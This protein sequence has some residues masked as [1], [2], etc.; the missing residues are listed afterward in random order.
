MRDTIYR[1]DAIDAV[2]CKT[3]F[4][5]EDAIMAV[6]TVIGEVMGN[7]AELPSAVMG[8]NENEQSD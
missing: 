8:E 7:I 4:E 5:S 3:T 2:K 1:D 6:M